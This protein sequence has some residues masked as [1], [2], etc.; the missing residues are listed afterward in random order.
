MA[1]PLGIAV[2]TRYDF[3]AAS[4]TKAPSR[5][6]V[7]SASAGAAVTST[8]AAIIANRFTVTVTTPVRQPEYP[9]ASS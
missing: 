4:L 5:S 7:G 8:S 3:A 2:D 9:T 1:G 6:L